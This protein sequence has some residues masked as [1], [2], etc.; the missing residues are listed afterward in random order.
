MDVSMRKK[1]VTEGSVTLGKPAT[2]HQKAIVR[3]RN[4]G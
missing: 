3:E 1:N 2:G 4:R